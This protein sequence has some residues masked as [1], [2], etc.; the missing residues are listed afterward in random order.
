MRRAIRKVEHINSEAVFIR[1]RKVSYLNV[2][3]LRLSV[4]VKSAGIYKVN[5]KSSRLDFPLL[6]G[7]AACCSGVE[8]IVGVIGSRYYRFILARIGLGIY[9]MVYSVVNKV[10]TV[11][12]DSTVKYRIKRMRCAVVNNS[13]ACP[14]VTVRLPVLNGYGFGNYLPCMRIV[15]GKLNVTYGIVRVINTYCNRGII[16]SRIFLHVTYILQL[17]HVSSEIAGNVHIYLAVKTVVIKF[18]I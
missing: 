8:V 14:I 12:G 5:G 1:C 16:I 11:T 9:V 10:N 7:F 13:E 17:N 2:N 15:S 4:I 6:R 18:I 3:R